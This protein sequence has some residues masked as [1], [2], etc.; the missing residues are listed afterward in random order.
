MERLYIIW[1]RENRHSP[2]L[3]VLERVQG[4]ISSLKL[5]SGLGFNALFAK[6]VLDEFHFGD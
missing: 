5:N 1:V 6:G 2:L 3:D 4:L